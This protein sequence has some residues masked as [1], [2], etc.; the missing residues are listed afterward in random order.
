MDDIND[1]FGSAVINTD[2]ETQPGRGGNT[3]SSKD[4][5]CSE[6]YAYCAN[7]Y[8]IRSDQ[9]RIT[10]SPDGNRDKLL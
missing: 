4:R 10:R 8:W 2:K 1:F 6:S 7:N 5:S 9:S 3:G